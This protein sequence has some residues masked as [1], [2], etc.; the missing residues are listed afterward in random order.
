MQFACGVPAVHAHWAGVHSG[1]VNPGLH[2]A[3][4]CDPFTKHADPCA[5]VPLSHTHVFTT[6]CPGF[7]MLLNPASHSPHSGCRCVVH[8]APYGLPAPVQMHRLRLHTVPTRRYP[9]SHAAHRAVWCVGHASA[10]APVPCAHVHVFGSHSPEPPML[11]PASH[12]T[13][14]AELF[15]RH[16]LPTVAT[17]CAQVHT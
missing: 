15:R 10:V 8:P 7:A 1:P 17:P 6:Q 12:D 3:H 14:Y 5:G 4:V 2:T 11:Y 9:S 16:S 13:Q